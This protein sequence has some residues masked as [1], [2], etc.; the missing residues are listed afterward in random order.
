M[1]CRVV[2]PGEIAGFELG[3]GVVGVVDVVGVTVRGN[4]FGVSVAKCCR[5]RVTDV[6]ADDNEVAGVSAIR[7]SGS[8]LRANG[9]GE[10][11]VH[12]G[13]FRLARVMATGNG[14]GGGVQGRGRLTDSIVVGNAGFDGNFD[15]LA[16]PRIRTRNSTCGK[17]IRLRTIFEP[18]PGAGERT[19]VLGSFD[20]R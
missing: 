20:C 7:L 17:G 12:A 14:P 5:L 4:K 19:K 1:S 6:T 2:G 3:V 15:L 8:G 18:G 13:R 11:G 16:Y 10:V 9:N